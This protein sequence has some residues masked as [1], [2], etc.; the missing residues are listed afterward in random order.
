MAETIINTEAPDQAAV[1]RDPLR[2]V[3]RL[4]IDNL[5]TFIIAVVM[6]VVIA[7]NTA[8]LVF[9][10][11]FREEA[12]VAASASQAADQ[13]LAVRRLVERVDA[14][15]RALIIRR[16]NSPAMAM[17]VTRRPIVQQSDDQFPSRVALR[18]LKRE[19]P[20]GTEI[21]VD[22]RID[23]GTDPTAAFPSDEQIREHMRG[24]DD[25][26]R[27][28]AAQPPEGLLS[29]EE[30]REQRMERFM[31]QRAHFAGGG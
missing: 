9:Y 11:V 13:V 22:S 25:V 14:P 26:A 17:A 19:F 24:E 30:R 23:R 2:W 28:D 29:R 20:P 1:R 18:R 31:V 10:F 16:M 3:Q 8:S 7:L 21:H 12:A 27:D 5:A 15:E 4:R 6:L